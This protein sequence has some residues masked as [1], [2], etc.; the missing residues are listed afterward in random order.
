[1]ITHIQQSRSSSIGILQYNE[2]K[3]TKGLATPVL[4]R[5]THF[6][7]IPPSESPIASI[8]GL[9]E[10]LESNPAVSRRMRSPSFHMSVNPS[11]TDDMP[12]EKALEYIQEV[13]SELGYGEQPYIVYRH[14]DIEREHW[15]VVSTK[16]RPDGTMVPS[17]FEGRRLQVIQKTLS[18]KYGFTPGLKQEDKEIQ[19]DQVLDMDGH[20]Y[21]VF[22][23]KARNKRK[24]IQTIFSVAMQFII[25]SLHEFKCIMASMGVHVDERKR[26]GKRFFVFSG[27]GEDGSKK[28]FYKQAPKNDPLRDAVRMVEDNIQ[29]SRMRPLSETESSLKMK[30]ASEYVASVSSSE[31]E[32][33]NKMKSINLLVT[34]ERTNEEGLSHL[35]IVSRRMRVA[36]DSDSGTIEVENL[37]KME[38]SGRWM[39]QYRGRPTTEKARRDSSPL[40]DDQMA[41]LKKRLSDIGSKTADQKDKKSIKETKKI[42]TKHR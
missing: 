35:T 38:E 25:R 18:E 8:F 17:E 30:A 13:M 28:F 10:D 15:H 24:L 39:Q 36:L 19:H 32:Y 20:G 37:R 27:I 9:F 26:N 23:P 1:M 21:P 4:I 29:E 31:Q 33:I 14:N 12:E 11:E 22:N 40:T 2:D 6:D 5:N 7:D 41:E 34:T 3:V 16:I 42:P